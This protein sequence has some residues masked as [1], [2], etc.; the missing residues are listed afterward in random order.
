MTT[1]LILMIVLFIMKGIFQ[2][3]IDASSVSCIH[4][5]SNTSDGITYYQHC[6]FRNVCWHNEGLLFKLTDLNELQMSSFYGRWPI[7]NLSAS[8]AEHNGLPVYVIPLNANN[9]DHIID[10]ALKVVHLKEAILLHRYVPSNLMHVLHDDVLPTFALRQQLIRMSS[11][12]KEET[13]SNE[14]IPTVLF[15][16]NVHHRFDELYNLTGMNFLYSEIG[17]ISCVDTLYIGLPRN[18][19]W[20]HYGFKTPQGPLNGTDVS[21]LI[22][23]RQTIGVHSISEVPLDRD[24]HKIP[25]EANISKL[26]S[27]NVQQR[28]PQQCVLIIRKSNRRILNVDI[29][30]RIL[31]SEYDCNVKV[32]SFDEMSLR[33]L[34]QLIASTDLLIAMHGAELALSIFLPQ[35]ASL[36][37]LFPY[38]IPPDNYAP[39]KTLCKLLNIHY[40]VWK[41]EVAE[42][43]IG[44]MKL[45]TALP[46]KEKSRI[47]N[48]QLIK[49]HLCCDDP[50][51]LYRI[52]Q[53]TRI[54][55]E[56]FR[57]A[58]KS[59]EIFKHHRIQCNN[60]M[61]PFIQQQPSIV[62][63]KDDWSLMWQYLLT[64]PSKNEAT[65]YLSRVRDPFC[66]RYDDNNEQ[67]IIARWKV[68]FNYFNESKYGSS[69]LINNDGCS[70]HKE[71]DE[72]N[73]INN[74]E[75]IVYEILSQCKCKET[76]LATTE[77]TFTER[78]FIK[79][80]CS[81]QMILWIKAK[82]GTDMIHPIIC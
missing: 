28:R 77:L 17:Q 8:S 35:N 82:Q 39:Y 22:Q 46:Q 53:D 31:Q 33:E 10:S 15:T 11:F 19:Q 70:K 36:L 57:N 64:I 80:N 41:N 5:G 27:E 20:Y 23:F 9:F 42:N 16:D 78:T 59:L 73:K 1:R 21:V 49:P 72:L 40:G 30:E 74:N 51:W 58:L 29:V 48:E 60:P 76:G 7:R 13:R 38:A 24:N 68:P 47:L 67:I 32:A 63:E 55:P 26:R 43:S 50:A 71:G 34:R 37:E 44:D 65:F 18:S 4:K 66:F 56:S 62:T 52:Y 61:Y 54:E 75:D 14:D 45:L 79:L 25:S 81:G 6:I 12:L 69:K 2:A 3:F